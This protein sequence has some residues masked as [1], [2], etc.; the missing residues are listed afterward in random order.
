V[1][2]FLSAEWI[3]AF[4]RAAQRASQ[5]VL[6]DDQSDLVIQHTVTSVP[7][8][9]GPEVTF[10]L[11][12]TAGP[13]RV[14]AGPADDPTVTFSQDHATAIG[15]ASGATSAQAAFMAGRLRVGGRIDELLS[16]QGP[17]AGIDDLFGDLRAATEF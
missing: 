9:D 3:D 12:L 13:A 2:R 11:R 8:A 15:V 10:H 17:L 7:G 4:D 6:D 1:P 14:A 16:R 5:L